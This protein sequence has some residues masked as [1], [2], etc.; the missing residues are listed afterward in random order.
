MEMTFAEKILANYANEKET[1]PGQIVTVQPAHLLTHDNTAA[2]IQKVDEELNKYGVY[3]KNLSIIVLDH[4]IPAASEKTAINHKK[5]RE[6]VAKHDIKHFYDVG[7][8][9]CHQVVVE[10]G[11][12]LP[13]KLLLGS[14]SH[15][16]S[17]GAV[18]S[19]SSGIDRTEAASL[20]LTGQT[21][22]KVPQSIK[23]HIKG[24]LS[25]GVYAKDVIL[26]IIGDISA[27]GA[28]YCSVEYH[29]EV[30]QFSVDDR[31]TIANM[32]VEMGAKNSVFFVDDITKQ[33][34]KSIGVNE[35]AYSP[36]IPDLGASYMQTLDYDLNNVVPMVA[37]PHTVD[38]VKPAD[39]L[40]DIEIHQCL[41]GTCTNGRLSDLEIAASILKGKK[42]HKNVR[43]LI[44]PASKQIFQEAMQK[45][46]IQVLVDSGGM[47]LPPGCGPCLGAH[48]GVLSPGERC[49]STANRNFKGR[50]GS[51][52]A[53]IYLASP[54]T[55]AATALNQTIT[56]P[57]EVIE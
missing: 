22:L 54:A 27:S 50:M 56:D 7:E 18:G 4:V 46:I 47:V 23:V 1:I 45:G 15:T 5:I 32:G 17:Y 57:R 55:V 19:F 9:V 34:L 31:F 30:E 29:G 13:G 3:S 48:Q 35:S 33:Y 16:C 41:I 28:T 14:D 2:I 10:K 36:V 37:C 43:L 44:I 20:M 11:L 39:Q 25:K 42:I 53:E 49:L 24:S 51:K 12:A 40:E 38:N 8:G 26:H 52:D 6:F 21:W